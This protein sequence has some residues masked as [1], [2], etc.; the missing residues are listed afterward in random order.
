VLRVLNRQ[1]VDPSRRIVAS[2]ISPQM[3]AIAKRRLAGV[4]PRV[5]LRLLDAHSMPDIPSNSVDL[6]S[7]SLGLKICNR[8]AVLREALRVL[9]PAGRLIVLEASNI[10]PQWLHRAYL[11]YMSLVMPLIGW[12][13][14]GGDAAAYRYLLRG[15]REF[16][17]AEQLAREIHQLGFEAVSFERL[18]LGIVAIHVATKPAKATL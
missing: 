14:T 5:E 12:I 3:L 4:S 6:Y 18:S 10:K 7:I 17:T 8:V 9:K 1:T 16:P 11:Q 13:A 15:V 2:D